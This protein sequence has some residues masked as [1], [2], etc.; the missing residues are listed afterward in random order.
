MTRVSLPFL[1]GLTTFFSLPT[2][3]KAETAETPNAETTNA[4]ATENEES[5]DQYFNRTNDDT[6]DDNQPLSAQA[7]TEETSPAADGAATSTAPA[8]T[9]TDATA[10]PA[11]KVVKKKKKKK[12]SAMSSDM[13][14][15][16][17][18][19]GHGAQESGMPYKANIDL[20]LKFASQSKTTKFKDRS[21]KSTETKLGLDVT[22]LFIFSK[23]EVGPIFSYLSTTQKEDEETTKGSSMGIGGAFFMNFGNIHADKLV[24]YAGVSLKMNTETNDSTKETDT[25]DSTK[26]TDKDIH[27]GLQG[28]MKYFV[29]AHLALK[30]FLSYEMAINGEYKNESSSPASVGSVTGSNLELGLG[31]AKYF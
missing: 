15:V 17:G 1:L 27:L 18:A 24:P 21:V 9:T 6:N 30:P 7:T 14:A 13:A 2:I 16:E 11:K 12:A 29:G 5:L 25:D 28:G 19:T 20:G 23:M 31:L 4:Q 8:D 10:A 3:S 22:W 26:E